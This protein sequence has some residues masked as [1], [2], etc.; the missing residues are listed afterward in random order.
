[1][2]Q[3]SVQVTTKEDGKEVSRTYAADVTIPPLAARDFSFAII[4]GDEGSKYSWT[5]ADARGF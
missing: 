5:I 2:T 4:I 3:V 1:V